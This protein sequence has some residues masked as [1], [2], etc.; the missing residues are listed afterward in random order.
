MPRIT[1][2]DDEERFLAPLLAN[3][4]HNKALVQAYNQGI[5]D[6]R[7]ALREA[8]FSPEIETHIQ[9]LRREHGHP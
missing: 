9:N 7:Q 5:D 2:T 3:Y 4:R 8:G 6:A 1:V